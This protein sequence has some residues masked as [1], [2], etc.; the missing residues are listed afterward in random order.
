MKLNN[1]QLN[2]IENVFW[3]VMLIAFIS[4]VL[5]LVITLNEI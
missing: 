4:I 2:F 5:Q 1:K 3:I